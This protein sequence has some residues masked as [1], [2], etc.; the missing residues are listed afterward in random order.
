M[1]IFILSQPK[2]YMVSS[3]LA[4][5]INKIAGM[6]LGLMGY[7][8]LQRHKRNRLN[9]N[10]CLKNKEENMPHLI[11]EYARELQLPVPAT[12]YALHQTLLDSGLF[13]EVDIK[14]RA[15]LC[16]IIWSAARRKIVLFILNVLVMDGAAKLVKK[17]WLTPLWNR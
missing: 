15:S 12:L 5:Y 13:E 10:A 3:K 4:F 8:L 7:K 2:V 14:I 1:I 9:L 17:Q 16:R 6:L 11:I